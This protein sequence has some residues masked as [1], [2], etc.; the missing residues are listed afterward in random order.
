MAARAQK[1]WKHV[2]P[3][4]YSTPSRRNRIALIVAQTQ[5]SLGNWLVPT[6]T[7]TEALPMIIESGRFAGDIGDAYTVAQ[8]FF[9]ERMLKVKQVEIESNE[10]TDQS[11]EEE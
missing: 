11:N 5:D 9:D 3:I 6:I 2:I 4:R 10:I 1:I 8:H 7:L